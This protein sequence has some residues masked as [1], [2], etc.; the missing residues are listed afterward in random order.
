MF[1]PLQPLFQSMY[2]LAV[3][4]ITV[5]AEGHKLLVVILTVV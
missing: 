1:H 5:G 4:N 3:E 2:V